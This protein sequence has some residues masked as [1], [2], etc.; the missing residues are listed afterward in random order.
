MYRTLFYVNTY[1]SYKLSK[2]SLFMAQ[3]VDKVSQRLQLLNSSNVCQWNNSG[4]ENAGLETAV[5]VVVV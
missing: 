5:V 2:N 1:G 4:D 3:P